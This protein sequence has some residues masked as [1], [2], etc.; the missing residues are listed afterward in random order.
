MT[1]MAGV[2]CLGVMLPLILAAALH[3]GSAIDATPTPQT[4]TSPHADP[5]RPERGNYNVSDSNKTVCLLAYLG[6]QLNVSFNS[7]SQNKVVQEVVNIKPNETNASGSCATEKAI[8]LLT[9]DGE[10]T[11]LTFAFTLNTTSRKYH[12]SEVSLSAA[13]PDMKE[14]ISIKNV[15]VDFLQGTLGHSYL[16]R[17][18]Q[19]L[20]VSQN[21]SIN[22][23]Q[24]Q[25]QPFGVTGNQ[26]GAA[27]ECQLD[28]DNLLIP[29]IVGA[30][31]A[32]L[33]LIVLLA[34]LIGRKR[35]HAGYQTI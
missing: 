8:L 4:T 12:L 28:V 27:E 9:S 19:T 31:L 33:V 1:Q 7:A 20:F 22:I 6:L 35:S 17:E 25:V 2:H 26:F 13:W 32:G 30:A 14:P 5:G 18:E 29:I 24:V 23:F 34:Y 11:N 15:S 3:Q 16:C 21:L 10:T